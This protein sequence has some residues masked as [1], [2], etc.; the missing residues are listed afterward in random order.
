MNCVELYPA[1]HRCIES[2]ARDEFWNSAK[3]YM[4]G[5]QNDKRLEERI[6]LLKT[7]LESADFGKLR[8][9]SEKHLAEGKKVKFVVCLREGD[10]HHEM[11]VGEEG[12][13]EAC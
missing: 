6:K 7:F 8:S 2:T 12:S 3:Q 13:P 9:Q 10:L 5:G 4:E 11:V 1:L